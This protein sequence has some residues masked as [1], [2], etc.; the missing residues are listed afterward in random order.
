M[1]TILIAIIIPVTAFVTG[2]FTLKGVQLGLNN[3]SNIQPSD[4]ELTV[5]NYHEPHD[6]EVNPIQA[7]FQD[8]PKEEQDNIINEWFHGVEK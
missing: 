3:P 1:V 2:Y 8:K 4:K 5:E 6:E 7:I